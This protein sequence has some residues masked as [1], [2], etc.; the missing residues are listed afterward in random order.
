MDLIR[1]LLPSHLLVIIVIS[2][3]S[4]IL[5]TISILLPTTDLYS[6]FSCAFRI[7]N[8]IKA[9]LRG[10]HCICNTGCDFIFGSIILKYILK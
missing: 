4:L 9:A 6:Y 1:V 2:L 10:E 8:M 3:C 7:C 5:N